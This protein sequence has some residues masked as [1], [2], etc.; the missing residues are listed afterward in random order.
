MKKIIYLML[1]VMLAGLFGACSKENPFDNGDTTATGGLL[2]SALDVSLKSENG[3]RSL[4]DR[5]VRAAAPD[6]DNF[7]VEFYLK[8]SQTPVAVY[9]YKDMPEIITLPVGS[10][11]AKAYYGDNADAAWDNPYYEG[12]T[13]FT[14]VEDEITDKVDPIVCTFANVRVSIEFSSELRKVMGTDCEVEVEVGEVGSL[15]FTVAD[16]EAG[17]SGYFRYVEG[18]NTLAATFRGTVDGVY[19]TEAKTGIDVDAGKHYSITF[20]LHDAGEEDPGFI[21][22]PSESEMVLVDASVE[23]ENIDGSVDSDETVIEDDLRPKEEDPGNKD[24]EP[25]DPNKPEDP[26]NAAPEVS[27][28]AP[29]VMDVPYQ[30]KD[31]DDT[32]IIIRAHSSAD[33]G[34]TA[35]LLDMSIEGADLE[36]VNLSPHMDLSNP[37]DRELLENIIESGTGVKP[38]L[39][40]IGKSDF[41]LDISAFKPML[42]VFTGTHTFR[43]TVRDA[44]GETVK[45]LIIKV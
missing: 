11:T 44:N 21:V 22:K 23:S 1:S 37:Q 20:R 40:V 9:K 29:V 12:T 8:E 4:K 15:L 2:T 28:M 30:L 41:Q 25:D 10:Y 42:Q 31:G 45:T 17:R 7:T 34:F 43:V 27:A 39:E 19:T 18:S 35:F 3:P 32:A 33:G 24:P 6:V 36:D 38:D 5:R 16:V 26:D 14:I 13:T